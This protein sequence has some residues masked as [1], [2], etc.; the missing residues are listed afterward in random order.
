V[1]EQEARSWAQEQGLE[2]IE[3]SAKTGENVEEVRAQSR[4]C[5]PRLSVLNLFPPHRPSTLLLD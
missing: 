3:T 2:Y 1:S 4:L 5:C